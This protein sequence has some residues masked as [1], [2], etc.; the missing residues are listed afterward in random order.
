M[1]CEWKLFA[2]GILC[3]AMILGIYG[4]AM[5]GG[6]PVIIPNATSVGINYH[7]EVLSRWGSVSGNLYG[8]VVPEGISSHGEVRYENG[9]LLWSIWASVD[10]SFMPTDGTISPEMWAYEQLGEQNLHVTLSAAEV[11]FEKDG[12]WWKA[13]Y[14]QVLSAY[15]DISAIVDHYVTWEIPEM[16]G[17]DYWYGNAWVYGSVNN[18]LIKSADAY[19]SRTDYNDRPSDWQAVFQVSGISIPGVPIK[20]T[21]LSCEVPE[22]ATAALLGLGAVWCRRRRQLIA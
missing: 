6:L 7:N 10:G 22:P 21:S 19:F 12:E 16:D 11:I 1:K 2:I 9:Q 4:E 3:S 17:Q 15:L 5:A 20:V 8:P 13:E 18:G 14:E